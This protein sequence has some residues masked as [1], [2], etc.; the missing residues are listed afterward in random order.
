MVNTKIYDSA[1][2]SIRDFIYYEQ[3]VKGRSELTVK[4]YF[5]DLRTFFRFYKIR[6]K[7]A[8]EDD[9]SKID[10]S[11]ITDDDVK[12]VDLTLAQE[13]LVYMKTQKNN[14]QKARYRK[15]VSLRQFYKFLT[16][17]KNMFEVSPVTNLEL[18]SPKPALPKFLTLEQSLELLVFV[19][20]CRDK[21]QRYP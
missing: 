16:N 11:D 15:A 5:N 9:F 8:P 18:P 19:G 7:G 17:N 10:I 4:N 6:K 12:Y 21:S 14:E 3:I 2:Q 1:P 13:F 20:A